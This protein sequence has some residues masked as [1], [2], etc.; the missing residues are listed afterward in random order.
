MA[1]FN[2]VILV[3]NV[4]RPIELKYTTG[5]TAVCDLGLAINDK[6]KNASGEWVEDTT[7]VDVTCFGRTAEVAAEYATKGSPVLIDGKLKLD[8]W[9][10]DGQRRSKLKVTCDRLQLLG[11]KSDRG[12]RTE[13]REERTRGPS[14]AGQQAARE[15]AEESGDTETPF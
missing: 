15:F 5:G 1:S 3:G 7:F 2:S 4:T 6:R 9:E 10:Q 11:S 8:T 13:P 12:E 14:Q